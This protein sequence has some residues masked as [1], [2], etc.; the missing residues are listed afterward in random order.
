M[1]ITFEEYNQLYDQMDEKLFNN[2]AFDACRVMDIHTTGI[3]NVAKLRQYS[4][5]DE[6]DIMVVKRCAAIIIHLMKQIQEAEAAA[7]ISRGYTETEQG[8][9]RRIISRV[10]SGNEA[11]SYSDA[12]LSNTYIDEAVS[13]KSVRDKLFADTVLEYLNGVRDRNGVNLL[14]MGSYPRRRSC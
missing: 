4:P 13:D 12:K 2:L 7:A 6:Y 11:I 14:Y 3:D 1:Y 10:E 5:T 9:Q 8:L